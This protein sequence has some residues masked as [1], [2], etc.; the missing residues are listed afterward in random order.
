[1]IL[2]IINYISKISFIRKQLYLKKFLKKISKILAKILYGKYK[3]ISIANKY[4]FFIDSDFAFSNFENWSSGHN[5]GFAKLLEISKN[6]KVVFDIGAHIGLCTLP[7]S[8]LATKIFSFEASPSNIKY[9]KKHLK[10]NKNTNVN[11][12]PYLV[13]R[14]N[15]KSVNFYNVDNGSGIPSIVNLRIKKKNLNISDLKVEQ[16]FLD[17]YVIKKSL[18]PDVLKIDVEGAEFNVLDGATRILKEHRPKIIISLHPEHLRLLNR[19][20]LEI[21][22]YC[23]L[24]SY[25]LL[26]C[27]DEHPISSDEI[28]L[29]EYYMKPM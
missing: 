3:K 20:I 8:N 29:D 11:V 21:Y 10:I 15:L 25:E 23:N 19:N 22:D 12:V 28:G 6:K 4:T 9:L 16:I 13:G 1:M 17:D 5:K 7:L 2:K 18:I 14:E 26:S 24:Y 27:I